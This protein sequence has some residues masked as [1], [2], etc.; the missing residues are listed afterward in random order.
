MVRQLKDN[1]SYLVACR[2][3]RR[4]AAIDAVEPEVVED[5]AVKLG[6]TIEVVLSTHHHWDHAGKNEEWASRCCRRDGGGGG[7]GD[8]EGGTYVTGST[9][10]SGGDGDGGGGGNNMPIIGGRGDG[11]PSVT[12]EVDEGDTVSVGNVLFT[13]LHTPGHTNGHVCYLAG[14]AGEAVGGGDGAASVAVAAATAATATAA[15]S[16]SGSGNG[17]GGG[18]GSDGGGGN[19][20]KSTRGNYVATDVFTGDTLF[21]GGCGRFFEGT[22]A[23]MHVS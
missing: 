11:V 6:L 18:G 17:G 8:R 5:V 19:C 21:I 7:G 16:S 4:A 3:T 10:V 13:I 9:Y 12:R 15:V 1:F 22:P 2:E 20:E 14:V 23:Q